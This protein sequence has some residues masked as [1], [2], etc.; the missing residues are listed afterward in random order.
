MVHS[1]L[2]RSL[3]ARLHL[4]LSTRGLALRIGRSDLVGGRDTPLGGRGALKVIGILRERYFRSRHF[5]YNP[6]LDLQFQRGRE[7]VF[8]FC[9]YAGAV[10]K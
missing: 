8:C 5:R 6:A 3:R 1:C 2:C 7:V 10:K 4:R 9:H